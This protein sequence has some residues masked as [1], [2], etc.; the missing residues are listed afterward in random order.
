VFSWPVLF[1][2]LPDLLGCLGLAAAI[3]VALGS[4]RAVTLMS[5]ARTGWPALYESD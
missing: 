4:A 2:A 3:G 1:L 5:H